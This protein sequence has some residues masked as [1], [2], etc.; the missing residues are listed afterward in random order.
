[1]TS[2]SERITFVSGFPRCGSSMVMQMLKAGGFPLFYDEGREA[3][4][5][6]TLIFKLPGD[7]AWL[8]RCQ[9]RAVK[10]LDPHVYTPP[11]ELSYDVIWLE[12]DPV[13]QARSQVKLLNALGGALNTPAERLLAQTIVSEQ[14]N[15]LKAIHQI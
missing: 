7:C 15:A 9:G 10:L 1:M 3:A 11:R 14:P 13:E 4:Y 2:Q 12:R 5:E 6:T 8:L